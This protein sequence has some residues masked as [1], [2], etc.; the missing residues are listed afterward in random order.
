MKLKNTKLIVF[1]ILIVLSG[2]HLM[3]QTH[4]IGVSYEPSIVTSIFSDFQ[5]DTYPPSI[6]DL[7]YRFG[8]SFGLDYLL[9]FDTKSYGLKTGC[10]FID[11]GYT[12]TIKR[13]DP[14]FLNRTDKIYYKY[15]SIPIEFHKLINN[16]YFNIGPNLNYAIR[17][18]RKLGTGESVDYDDKH[19]AL[20]FKTEIGFRFEYRDILELKIGC[21]NRL[22]LF[23][24]GNMNYG[25]LLN[26]N[27]KINK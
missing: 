12:E 19:F 8:N 4:F 9:L 7:F 6:H 2:R 23:A 20:G 18:M 24:Q 11:N 10:Y 21:F 27:Y 25:V 22:F 5:H 14:A 17:G 13:D 26:L 1:M 15:I 3:C 16:S